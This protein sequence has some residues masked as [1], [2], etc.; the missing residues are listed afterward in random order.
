MAITITA[1]KK[2]RCNLGELVS[3]NGGFAPI[4]TSGLMPFSGT[5]TY[6]GTGDVC[7]GTE[8]EISTPGLTLPGLYVTSGSPQNL[9]NG[10]A[11]VN[12]GCMLTLLSDKTFEDFKTEED[13]MFEQNTEGLEEKA[14]R[15]WWQQWELLTPEGALTSNPEDAESRDAVSINSIVN[16]MCRKLKVPCSGGVVGKKVKPYSPSGNILSEIGN[17]V[18]YSDTPSYAY[19]DGSSIK[20]KRIN[21]RP[22]GGTSIVLGQSGIDK[23]Y[24]PLDT[25]TSPIDRLIV[26][27]SVPQKSEECKSIN[28]RCSSLSVSGSAS[29][30]T[31]N[32]GDEYSSEISKEEVCEWDECNVSGTFQGGLGITEICN[33]RAIKTTRQTQ[34]AAIFSNAPPDTFPAGL[35]D[36]YWSLTN[37]YYS[38]KSGLLLAEVTYEEAPISEV[39]G[40]WLNSHF[41]WDIESNTAGGTGWTG[42]DM[43]FNLAVGMKSMTFPPNLPSGMA[44]SNQYDMRLTPA[45]YTETKYYYGDDNVVTGKVT[46]VWQPISSVLSDYNGG[47]DGSGL[48]TLEFDPGITKDKEGNPSG[49]YTLEVDQRPGVSVQLINIRPK[50]P[51]IPASPAVGYR[52]AVKA[53]PASSEQIATFQ[54]SAPSGGTNSFCWHSVVTSEVKEIWKYS[55]SSVTHL[56]EEKMLAKEISGELESTLQERYASP[57]SVILKINN[58]VKDS[59]TNLYM[60]GTF[61]GQVISVLQTEQPYDYARPRVY[62]T[63]KE[64]FAEYMRINNLDEYISEDPGSP[65]PVP[66]GWNGAVGGVEGYDYIFPDTRIIPTFLPRNELLKKVTKR[67]ISKNSSEGNASPGAS[68]YLSCAVATAGKWKDVPGLIEKKGFACTKGRWDP[69]TE[70]ID[71]GSVYSESVAEAVADIIMELR[72]AQSKQYELTC[73]VGE[74]SLSLLPPVQTI[75]ITESCQTGANK[76]FV[77]NNMGVT[78]GSNEMLISCDL[79]MIG[80]N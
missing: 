69:P 17:L 47:C 35:V 59:Q 53:Q 26:T 15:Y 64:G 77:A 75:L 1:T 68:E 49:A 38:S 42:D 14:P 7:W 13:F 57:I 33:V 58:N 56:T 55:C 34:P 78:I 70:I 28:Q 9:Y 66:P 18:F 10:Q 5:L 79:L 21:L 63:E 48:A 65:L 4:D 46:T 30:I 37:M 3:F 22:S 29:I 67:S 19:C 41:N 24:S 52:P 72:Q 25:G 40:A 74:N 43:Q 60:P 2:S 27:Y 50:T 20:I 23:D 36:S 6:I 71:L 39:Y 16:E 31:G 54:I 51:A 61:G 44:G 8:V 32:T 11:T 12:V 80:G 45:K 76:L 62:G 73:R